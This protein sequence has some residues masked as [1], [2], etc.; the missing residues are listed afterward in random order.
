MATQKLSERF[1]RSL[2]PPVASRI[3]INDELVRGLCLRHSASGNMSWAVYYRMP[4]N[5]RKRRHNLGRYPAVSLAMAR[6]LAREALLQAQ[7]GID[8]G[9][10]K[11]ALREAPTIAEVL[12]EYERMEASLKASGS[13]MMRLLRKDV[14]PAWGHRKAHEIT[15]RDAVLLMDQVRERAPVTANRLHGRLSRLF[16]FAVERGI[17]EAS[18]MN[19]LRKSPESPRERVMSDDEIR[20]F[21]TGLDGSADARRLDG[22]KVGIGMENMTALALKMILITGQRPGEVC[23]M[24]WDEIEE[25]VW[26]LS[27]DRTKNGLEQR[28]PICAKARFILNAAKN[29]GKSSPYVFPHRKCGA[30]FPIERHSLSRA[31]LR[32]TARMGIMTRLTP[33]DLRRTVRT[34][35]AELGIDEIVA[36]RIMNHSL[37]GMARVY[38]RHH[39]LPEKRAALEAWDRK[40]DSL[41]NLKYQA[42]ESTLKSTSSLGS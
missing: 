27:K 12:A 25:E 3:E 26:V 38:N 23:G 37:Q 21:W 9:G 34:R 31:L 18:P 42:A 39:Y 20:L 2:K 32:N 16:N 14:M 33:H 19:R 11:R 6:Q 4:N 22:S 30:E 1:L 7:R 17:L 24:R 8:P 10:D 35:L 40:I 29:A 28:V 36:E 15:R 13:E 5:R 41:I